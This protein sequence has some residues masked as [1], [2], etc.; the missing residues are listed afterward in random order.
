MSDFLV[1][2]DLSAAEFA[3]AV[4]NT[5]ATVCRILQGQVVPRRAL[6]EAIHRETGGLV[7]PNDLLGLHPP[8]RKMARD[9]GRNEIE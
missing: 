3:R 7:T 2:R 4:G 1:D 6:I 5:A 9:Q 8:G